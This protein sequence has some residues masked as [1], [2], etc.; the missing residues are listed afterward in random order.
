MAGAQAAILQAVLAWEGV[1]ARP[2][3]FGGVEFGL[4]RREIGHIHG[5]WL[6]DIPFPRKVRD[7]VVAAGLAA[8]HHILPKSGWISRYLRQPGDVETAI[9]LLR[10][11]YAIALKQRS[12]RGL[13][14]PPS[15]SQKETP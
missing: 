4:G 2:H 9:A 14:H 3:R 6:V 13:P 10:R 12:K 15:A 5:D 1:T 8:P 7:E 11:S